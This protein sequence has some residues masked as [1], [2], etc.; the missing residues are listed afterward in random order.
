[1]NTARKGGAGSGTQPAALYFAGQLD[2]SP[3]AALSASEEWDGTNWTSGNSLSQ[4]R[5]GLAGFGTQTAT[6]ATG[7]Q[8][9][10]GPGGATNVESYDGT[11]W[12]SAPSLLNGVRNRPGGAGTLQLD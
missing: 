7:G 11:N 10:P 6:L 9:Y 8:I 3:F 5:L 1:M 2:A 12:T 4:A